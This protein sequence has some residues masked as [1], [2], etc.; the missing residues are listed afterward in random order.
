MLD[1]NVYCGVVVIILYSHQRVLK[2]CSLV[3]RNNIP[4]NHQSQKNDF[5]ED[6]ETA[7]CLFCYFLAPNVCCVNVTVIDVIEQT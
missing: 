4:G 2:T 7:V 5:G 1:A 6:W 3:N